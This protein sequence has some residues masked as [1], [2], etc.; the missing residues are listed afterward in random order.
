[1]FRQPPRGVETLQLSQ[2]LYGGQRARL[3]PS[4]QGQLEGRNHGR[5]VEG[6]QLGER[7]IVG[8]VS[9]VARFEQGVGGRSRLAREREA[10]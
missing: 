6:L 4:R 5:I 2:R 1:L 8:F 10:Y 7:E 3:I 9:G